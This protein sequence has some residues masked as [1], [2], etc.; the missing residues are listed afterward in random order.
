MT[1]SGIHSTTLDTTPDDDKLD[2][3]RTKRCARAL[4][5]TKTASPGTTQPQAG[6]RIA[7]NV[8]TEIA[9]MNTRCIMKTSCCEN[10]LCLW[11][12]NH[13]WNPYPCQYSS[14]E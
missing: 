6:R 9:T 10:G 7:R 5:K 1:P 8:A 3:I 14:A 2:A 12:A 4:I 11:S 13:L